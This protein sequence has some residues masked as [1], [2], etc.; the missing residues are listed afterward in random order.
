VTIAIAAMG[1]LGLVLIYAGLTTKPGPKPTRRSVFDRIARDAG[2]RIKGRTVAVGLSTLWATTVFLSAGITSSLIVSS[3]L[4]TAALWLPL[5]LLRTRADKRRRRFGDAW[6]DAIATL[7]AAVRAGV[8]LPE[9]CVGLTKRGPGELSPGFE[10]FTATYRATGSF[11]AALHRLREV[12]SDP[13]ADRVAV[14]LALAHEVGGTDL[15][16]VLRAI[17]DFVREDLRVRKEVEARWSWTVTAARV[18]AAAPWIVLL[19][20]STRPEAADAYDSITGA[21]IIAAGATATL[22]GYRLMLRAARL[23]QEP[24][25]PL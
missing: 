15:V 17:G 24:R 23:P 5:A 16:R 8:A 10:A 12:L 4:G 6:P 14:S 18:A 3:A 2:L 22:I 19:M 7:I 20:M 25:L 11:A 13:V 9:A 21:A 1:A